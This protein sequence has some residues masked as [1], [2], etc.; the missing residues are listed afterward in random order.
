MNSPRDP[1]VVSY[2]ICSLLDDAGFVPFN[3]I[4]SDSP[5]SWWRTLC[6]PLAVTLN[7]LKIIFHSVNP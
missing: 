7:Y 6:Y 2:V 4:K 3:P 1:N 5:N